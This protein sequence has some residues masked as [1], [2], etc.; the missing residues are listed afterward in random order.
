MLLRTL[1]YCTSLSLLI[2]FS[3]QDIDRFDVYPDSERFSALLSRLDTVQFAAVIDPAEA[4][5]ILTSQQIWLDIPANAFSN[6]YGQPIKDSVLIYFFEY[7]SPLP[8]LAK[9]L[10]LMSDNRY[11]IS[12]HSVFHLAAKSPDGSQ[13]FIKGQHPVRF[14]IPTDD[15]QPVPNLFIPLPDLGPDQLSLWQKMESNSP[16]LAIYPE[17]WS[18]QDDSGE[19]IEEQGWFIHAGSGSWVLLGEEWTGDAWVSLEC[20]VNGPFNGENGILYILSE[21]PLS[22]QKIPWNQDRHAF[23][24]TERNFPAGMK[25]YAFFLGEDDQN[26][27]Y[28]SLDPLVIQSDTTI[29]LNPVKRSSSQAIAL[30]KDIF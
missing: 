4:H 3:C 13:L 27:W 2:L 18:F 15:S 9:D 12:M 10:S 5:S 23:C 14:R 11:P 30:L 19:W 16:N 25:G 17:S 22:I 28:M 20:I 7:Y 24:T 8:L 1:F 26:T 21:S 6:E 29:Q